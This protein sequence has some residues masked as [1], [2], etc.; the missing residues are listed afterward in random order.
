MPWAWC[1]SIALMLALSSA[2]AQK[3]ERRE[4]RVKSC[5]AAD[6]VLGPIGDD[7]K[8]PVT[9]M[10]FGARDSTWLT[11]AREN[12]NLSLDFHTKLAGVPP[13]TEPEIQMSKIFRDA[14]GALLYRTT[15]PV[16][17]SFILQDTTFDAAL[18]DR[19]QFYGPGNHIAMP[20]SA[21]I[22][23]WQIGAIAQSK[24]AVIRY[25]SGDAHA[26]VKLGNGERRALRALYRAAVCPQT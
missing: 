18:A 24:Q 21:L 26:D 9:S 6:S 3:D 15:A 2:K 7:A 14:F 4:I 8:S 20:V 10:Y 17:V 23:P 1:I 13:T 25:A 19:G 16:K 5:P 22:A 11:T 12:A